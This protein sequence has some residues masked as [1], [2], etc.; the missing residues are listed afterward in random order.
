MEAH[1]KRKC[2]AEFFN[3]VETELIHN[4]WCFLNLMVRGD[5]GMFPEKTGVQYSALEAYLVLSYC[6]SQAGIFRMGK[7]NFGDAGV[8]FIFPGASKM[9]DVSQE[10]WDDFAQRI[11]SLM[12]RIVD[13]WLKVEDP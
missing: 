4:C 13:K 6:M 12:R 5:D 8:H 1:K 3:A 10:Q 9:R 7:M 11:E 2:E